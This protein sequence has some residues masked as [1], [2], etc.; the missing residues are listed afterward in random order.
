MKRCP[1]SARITLYAVWA[2]LAACVL[3]AFALPAIL[4]WYGNVRN[5]PAA[6]CR[7]IAAAYYL[8]LAPAIAALLSLRRLLREILAGNVFTA[9]NVRRIRR[10]SWCCLP[11]AVASGAAAVFYLPL[12]FVTVLMLFLFLTVRVVA[13]A[14]RAACALREENELTI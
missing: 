1:I 3:L 7:A 12:C 2:S 9:E 14:F 11:V 4:R 8:S 5:M 10:V 6:P 13:E